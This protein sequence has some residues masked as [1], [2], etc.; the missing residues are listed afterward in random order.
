MYVG[1]DLC[2]TPNVTGK[3]KQNRMRWTEHVARTNAKGN[4]Y[5]TLVGEPERRPLFRWEGNIKM[6]LKE[7][8]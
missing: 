1:L 2:F 6:D 8:W 7:I 4:A 5:T 3:I